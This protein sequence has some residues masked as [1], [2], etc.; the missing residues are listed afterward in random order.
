MLI[1]MQNKETLDQSDFYIKDA[2]CETKPT[3]IQQV[4]SLSP[5]KNLSARLDPSMNPSVQKDRITE[6][7]NESAVM[8]SVSSEHDAQ[9][10]E[11]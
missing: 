4:N 3:K 10:Q 9:A 11:L 6:L 8:E 2:S 7:E 1:Q 5:L